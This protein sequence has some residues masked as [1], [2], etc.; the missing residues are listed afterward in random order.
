METIEE[1]KK[2]LQ[3]KLSEKRYMHSIGVMKMAQVLAKQHGEEEQT[4]KIVGLVHDIAKE[5][6]QEEGRKY[7]KENKIELD[8]IE[9]KNPA[10]WH[11][12]IGADI[13]QKKISLYK[14]NAICNQISYNRK[15][16]NGQAS[17]NYLYSR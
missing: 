16:T 2:E 5:I 1:M 13:V 7:I 6:P 11:A 8:E 9:E 3:K 15:P 14:A 4:A 12:K 10:L 17:K